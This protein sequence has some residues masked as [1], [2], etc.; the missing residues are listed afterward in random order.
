MSCNKECNNHHEQQ[1]QNSCQSQ[2]NRDCQG[3]GSLCIIVLYILLV[4][5]LGSLIIR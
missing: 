3:N 4:I 1:C 5:I 2:C